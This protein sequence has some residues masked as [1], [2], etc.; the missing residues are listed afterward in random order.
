MR[1]TH[2]LLRL[3][4]LVLLSALSLQ[5]YF[6]SRIALMRLVD[7]QSTTFQRSEG[8]RLW[9]ANVPKTWRQEWV[10]YDQV[11]NSMKRAV[12][13]SE[14]ASFA[15]HSGVDWEALEKAWERNQKAHARADQLNEKLA[16]KAERTATASSAAARLPTLKP[17]AE[18]KIIGGS[19]I[20]QQLAKNLFLGSER[21]FPRKAQEFVITLM[22]ERL[23]SKQRL[24][25]IYLNSVEWGEGIFGVQAAASYYY[26]VPARQ[27]SAGQAARLAVMLPAP[28]RFEKRPDSPYLASRAGTIMGR[29]PS[30]EL[31]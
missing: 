12:I 3:A 25:E 13:T 15:E 19:T 27:L 10:P 21:S 14:D 28:K 7:P 11:S 4:S 23:L 2:H 26:R 30:T 20:S 16:Q 29:M 9:R 22:L 5:L 6:A 18:P 1:W 8:W 17:R 24:L 31:P